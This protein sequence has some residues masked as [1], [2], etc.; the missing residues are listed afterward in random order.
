VIRRSVVTLAA[1]ALALPAAAYGQAD[2]ISVRG[3]S[4]GFGRVL[5]IGDFKPARNPTYAAA[6]RAYGEPGSQRSRS[7]GSACV[8]NWPRLGVRIVFANFGVGSACQRNR[9]RA[10]SA[11]GYGE[12][13]RTKRGLG[14]G[15]RLSRLRARYPGA[16]RHRRSWWLVTGVSLFGASRERYPVLAATVRDRR[17]RSFTLRIFAA[18]D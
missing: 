5:A 8:V 6:I 16:R 15:A 7:G 14:V 10:Q 9:G 4:K 17:V 13:W 11:R 2:T 12:D 18:G 3:S 1:L